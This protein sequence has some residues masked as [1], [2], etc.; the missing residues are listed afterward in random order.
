MKFLSF[1]RLF[2]AGRRPRP[3]RKL[4]RPAVCGQAH[5][6]ALER[7]EDRL[8]PAIVTWNGLGGNNLWSNG[9]N[10]V[11]GKAPQSGD[12]LVFGT[13]S[14][15]LNGETR[16]NTVL[17]DFP[18]VRTFQEIIFSTPNWILQGNPIQLSGNNGVGILD[19]APRGSLDPGTPDIN[20]QIGMG[21]TASQTFRLA[22]P[23][24]LMFISLLV[25]INGHTLTLE[26][27]GSS[28]LSI[29][30]K[31]DDPQSL[32]T[33]ASTLVKTGLGFV[34]LAGDNL[35]GGPTVIQQGVL[36]IQSNTALG[37]ALG[38]LVVGGSRQIGTTVMNG[39]SLQFGTNLTGGSLTVFEDLYLAGDGFNGLGALINVGSGQFQQPVYNTLVGTMNLE[40]PFGESSVNVITGGTLDHIGGI[41]QPKSG[42]QAAV[43]TVQSFTKFG[44]GAYITDG[45]GPDPFWTSTTTPFENLFYTNT[46]TGVTFVKD[47]ALVLNKEVRENEQPPGNPPHLL[48]GS[49]IGGIAANGSYTGGD[50][51]PTDPLLGSGPPGGYAIMGDLVIGD[52][53]GPR[54]SAQVIT[55]ITEPSRDDPT[56]TDTAAR[57]EE[58][59]CEEIRDTSNVTVN[60]DGFFQ[61]NE[62]GDPFR[63]Q[64]LRRRPVGERINT[65]TINNGDVDLPVNANPMQ[66]FAP[67]LGGNPANPPAMITG[68][69][70]ARALVM[71]GGTITGQTATDAADGGPANLIQGT[72]MLFA[73][74]ITTLANDTP[75]VINSLLDLGFTTRS[76]VD[77]H[78]TSPIDLDIQGPVGNGGL[79]VSASSSAGVVRLLANNRVLPPNITFP[80]ANGFD[81]PSPY[82]A[83]V[84][85]GNAGISVTLVS[86]TLLLAND[87]ALGSGQFV[88]FGGAV[89]SDDNAR[90]I[91]NS[92]SISGN[93]EVSGPASLTFSGPIF[94]NGTHQ[95]TVDL[96]LTTFSGPVQDVA[97]ATSGLYKAGAGILLYSGAT[98]NTYGGTT[99]VQSG[100][101]LLAKNAGTRSIAGGLFIGTGQGAPNSAVV[102][103]YTDNQINPAVF[104]VSGTDGS[105]Q[106]TAGVNQTVAGLYMSG[107]VALGGGG[108]SGPAVLTVSGPA[109]LFGATIYPVMGGGTLVLGSDLNAL[110]GY[111]PTAILVDIDLE[112]QNVH[113]FLVAPGTIL[114]LSGAVSGPSSIY[115]T[116]GGTLVFGGATPNTF[117]GIMWV[118][119]GS[120]VLSKAPGV[121]A[122]PAVLY[123]G[124]GMHSAV[125]GVVADQQIPT[126]ANVSINGGGMFEMGTGVTDF[127]NL[128]DVGGTLLLD[129]GSH[130]FVKNVTFRTG[131]VVIDN[132]PGGLAGY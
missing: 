34:Q 109:N 103:V 123:I 39:A 51:P 72:L 120:L 78:G 114:A 5:R 100:V 46:Y 41:K 124:D 44:G 69:L 18:D 10:W 50:N 92:V 126:T 105:F 119:D 125:V 25:R 63:I 11:G 82:P 91:S 62:Y 59:E 61:V 65:L 43:P 83:L 13:Y 12:I 90:N 64:I 15:G 89:Q 97:G 28:V 113:N 108:G 40:S 47:G 52:A 29:N 80:P 104:V 122:I 23:N 99:W 16:T 35:Y 112:S 101:L 9:T 121:T 49:R 81:W 67:Q 107:T 66:F 45:R 4:R 127:I 94:L 128:L 102:A 71:Q 96:N 1:A 7:L 27:N 2:G 38:G 32:N 30:G 76:I 116:G 3:A 87:A 73:G 54:D 129:P 8:A 37:P 57:V 115:K 19:Q 31:L 85:F 24:S 20:I 55:L 93:F 22:S 42:S 117:T 21:L 98:P 75:A 110:V 48:I 14:P 88:I 130:L 118:Q 60:R 17:N 70:L 79:T 6:P 86:G 33:G 84:D 132:S 131:A 111:S 68:T 77:I 26:A 74:G 53:T 106:L 58:I 56:T 36:A 95:M